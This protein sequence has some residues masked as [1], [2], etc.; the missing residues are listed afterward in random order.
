MRFFDGDCFKLGLG[1]FELA[2]GFFVAFL[3]DGA[4]FLKLAVLLSGR[5]LFGEFLLPSMII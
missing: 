3:R 2:P 5:A 4:D 1:F